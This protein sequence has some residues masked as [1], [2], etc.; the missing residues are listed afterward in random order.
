M[1]RLA[2]IGAGRTRIASGRVARRTTSSVSPQGPED[3]I[4]S[5]SVENNELNA[6][7]FRDVLLSRDFEVVETT[8]AEEGLELVRR[9]LDG[10]QR[11]GP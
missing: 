8:T 11:T 5:G 7:L 10:P 9:F 6:K 2:T 1:A 3:L 4:P